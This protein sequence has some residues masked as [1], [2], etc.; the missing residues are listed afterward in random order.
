MIKV[1]HRGLFNGPNP[2]KE[3]IP[4]QIR[5]ALYNG[6]HAEID[7]WF[8][9]NKFWLGHDKPRINVSKAIT[10]WDG[11]WTHCKNMDAYLQLKYDQNVNCFMHDN[12]DY[13]VTSRG[14]IWQ[15][16]RLGKFIF[17]ENDGKRTKV[18]EYSNDWRVIS[19]IEEDC[20]I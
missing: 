13:C 6:F 4:A 10:M 19:N 9:E 15:H 8:L 2:L 7:I 14:Y 17:T 18:G 3:N 16:E 20:S 5:L 12:E 1:A 11:V